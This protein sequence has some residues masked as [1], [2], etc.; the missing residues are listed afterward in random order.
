MATHDY[1]AT[2]P[3]ASDLPTGIDAVKL[4]DGSVSNAEFQ[5]LDGVT[6]AI[7]TQLDA[8]VA[9]PTGT[10][11][12]NA[13]AK[14]VEVPNGE[15]IVF[16]SG[17]SG[18]SFALRRNGNKLEI[19][20]SSADDDSG[21]ESVYAYWDNADGFLKSNFGFSVSGSSVLT[22]A[23]KL[24]DLATPDDNTDLN[25][26][27]S[28]HGLLKKLSNVST[29]FMNGV[30]NWATPAAVGTIKGICHAYKTSAQTIGAA[31][32]DAILYNAELLDTGTIHDTSTNTGRFVAP[33]GTTHALVEVEVNAGAGVPADYKIY[34]DGAYLTGYA[35]RSNGS[36]RQTLTFAFP[37]AAASY[38]ELRNYLTAGAALSI[39]TTLDDGTTVYHYHVRVTFVAMS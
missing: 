9:N 13:R 31:S 20:R 21:A 12:V 7:Q 18:D 24:D 3:S 26:S 34:V 25:A 28:A 11:T 14:Y 38:F 16:T 19:L 33:T 10:W 5:R 4:A 2:T 30:G 27:T 37:I 36:A 8:K 23:T 39:S 6:S 15:V 17:A 1:P 32:W 29:E 22:A 35:K